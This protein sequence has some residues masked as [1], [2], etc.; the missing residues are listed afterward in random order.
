MASEKKR[1]TVIQ[2]RRRQIMNTIRA[3]DTVRDKALG[4]KKLIAFD[5]KHGEAKTRR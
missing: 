2:I 5:A 1:A 4:R 3:A